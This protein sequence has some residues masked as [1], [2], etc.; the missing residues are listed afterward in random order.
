LKKNKFSSKKKP[1][2]N[3]CWIKFKDMKAYQRHRQ[4]LHPK[5]IKSKNG[6]SSADVKVKDEV[7]SDEDN[8]NKK[9]PRKESIATSYESTMNI[10]KPIGPVNVV[11]QVEEGFE[12]HDIPHNRSHVVSK[13]PTLR[14]ENPGKFR[15]LER[16]RN[17]RVHKAN[18]SVRE[19]INDEINVS[20]DDIISESSVILEGVEKNKIK[21]EDELTPAD[22]PESESKESLDMESDLFDTLDSVL[23]SSDNETSDHEMEPPRKKFK[24][25][26]KPKRIILEKESKIKSGDENEEGEGK[27]Q[28]K[29]VK[30]E[31]EEDFIHPNYS[32]GAY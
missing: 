22:A 4:I 8:P 23:M 11:A 17:M 16:R 2:C 5:L 18:F 9:S 27:I 32:P 20:I 21:Q 31:T 7:I 24:E 12:I 28:E 29:E 13:V 1:W 10:V 30:K 14:Y 15:K 19:N 6:E 26:V 3:Y 25:D